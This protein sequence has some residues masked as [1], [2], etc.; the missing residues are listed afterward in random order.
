M[1]YYLK[2]EFLNDVNQKNAGNKARNDVETVLNELEYSPLKVLV[3]DWYK[4]NVLEAQIHKYHAL[5]KAF[6]LLKRGDEIV[7][8][9]QKIWVNQLS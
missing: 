4:M 8:Q 3:D 5:S 2:E 7:I 1:K 6:K 9:F